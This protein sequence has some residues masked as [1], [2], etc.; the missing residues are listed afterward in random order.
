MKRSFIICLAI[1]FI[2]MLLSL[3]SSC[4]DDKGSIDKTH[5][6][7]QVS[8]VN[9]LSQIYSNRDIYINQVDTEYLSSKNREAAAYVSAI[10][11]NGN[12]V[13]FLSSSDFQI[14]IDGNS[15]T[16]G[17]IYFAPIDNF[18]LDSISIAI[19]MD[20]STSITDFPETQAAM[21]EAVIG[22]IDL[23]QPKDQA[24]I[25]KFNTGIKYLQPFTSDKSLLISAV[26]YLEGITGGYT[27]LYDTLYTAL[28]D[29]AIR[30]TGR[31]A[32]I[33]ITDGTERRV[34]GVPGDGREKKDIIALAQAKE[35]PIYIIGLGP[36]IDV[37]ELTEIT[38]ETSGYFY[39][40]TKID[41]LEDIYIN[42]SNLLNFGQY[43]FLFETTPNGIY[44]SEFARLATINGLSNSVDTTISYTTCP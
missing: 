12:P 22:F 44:H 36:N 32:V 40:A 3:F 2:L 19:I 33:A 42:I 25:I 18:I 15:V 28:E 4:T 14:S 41:Q 20:Y 27:Y 5:S 6:Q 34:E 29:T 13:Q 16:P 30:K 10:N 37:E 35:I 21:E 24:E 38:E 11:K 8:A 31:K 26:A 17:D 23:M 43:L 9:P 39:Q 1:F 7:G